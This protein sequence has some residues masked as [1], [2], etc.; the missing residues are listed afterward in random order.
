VDYKVH[1]VVT[2]KLKKTTNFLF[3]FAFS[4]EKFI[5][6]SSYHFVV[7]SVRLS[8]GIGSAPTGRILAKFGN[9]DIILK[10]DQK[11]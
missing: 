5:L 2:S 10:S 11:I 4:F 9:G 1:I 8:A 7:Q 3:T 6:A